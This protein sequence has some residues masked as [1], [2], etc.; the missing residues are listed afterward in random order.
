M[1]SSVLLPGGAAADKKDTRSL[2]SWVLY[3]SGTRINKVNKPEGHTH[4]ICFLEW[5][6]R[7]YRWTSLAVQQLSLCTPDAGHMGSIPGQGTKVP[8]AEW[9]SRSRGGEEVPP[10]GWLKTIEICCLKVLKARSLRSKCPQGCFPSKTC[11][12][13]FFLASS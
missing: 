3:P 12:K 9:G 5:P 13:E 4:Y 1:T 7:K 11:G 2:T 8:H 6:L 10:T